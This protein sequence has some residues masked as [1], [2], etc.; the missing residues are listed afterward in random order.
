ML[1]NWPLGNEQIRQNNGTKSLP[2]RK[3]SIVR[4]YII[5]ATFE[6]DNQKL[7]YCR[8]FSQLE[9]DVKIKDGKLQIRILYK[10]Y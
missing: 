3:G 6:G 5:M 1:C 4:V 2:R 8:V 10:F 7:K 9:M